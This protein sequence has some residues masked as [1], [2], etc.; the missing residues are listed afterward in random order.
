MINL[1]EYFPQHS[2]NRMK[3]EGDVAA[4]REFYIDHK[5]NNLFMLLKA[6]YGWM[7][8]YLEGKY[9]IIELGAGA[10]FSKF[11]LEKDIILTDVVKHNWI[12]MRIDALNPEI[13]DGSVDVI[14]CSHMIHHLASPMEFFEIV[15]KKLRKDGLI[16][17]QEIETSLVMKILL[18]IMRHEG[19]SDSVDVFDKSV[20]CNQASDPW[21]ANCSIPKLLF[22][23]EDKFHE[24]ITSFKVLK[25][26]VNEF[27][28]FPLSGGVI[29][30][31]KTINLPI[32]FL[33]FIKRFDKFAVWCLPGVFALGRSV[34]LKKVVRN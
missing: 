19:W 29:S 9:K 27:L 13:E 12:D 25:N 30:K 22:N 24:N 11:F 26:E 4:A 31:T 3:N 28:L 8:K 18:R 5:P 21:S 6:R 33:N 15:A 23:N 20:I 17:I 32:W 7:N 16:I 1:R 34:V 14:I 2:E 10:G